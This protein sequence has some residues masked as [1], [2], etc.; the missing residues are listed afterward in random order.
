LPSHYS[1]QRA[2]ALVGGTASAKHRVNQ[3]N[4]QLL[5]SAW[6]IRTIPADRN[7]VLLR[8]IHW[9]RRNHVKISSAPHIERVATWSAA[10]D[11][12]KVFADIDAD[13][14]LLK[15]QAMKEAQNISAKPRWPVMLLYKDAPGHHDIGGEIIRR[16]QK[17]LVN[18][19]VGLKQSLQRHWLKC[20]EQFALKHRMPIQGLEK[21]H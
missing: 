16:W 2:N 8:Y 10:M 12:S 9:A 14:P 11:R 20:L 3:V 18:P 19:T 21:M 1:I 15:V 4:I 6:Y 5:L 7:D 17:L 13:H